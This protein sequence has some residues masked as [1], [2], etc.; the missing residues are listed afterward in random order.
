MSLPGVG[1]RV[2]LI[3]N[4]DSFAHNL[5]QALWGLGAEVTV[6]R[7]DAIDRSGAVA[8]DPTHVVLSPG[9]GR[10]EV[11]RDFGVCAD[12]IDHLTDTPLLGVCLGH[13]GIAWRMGGAVV[14]APEIVHGKVDRITHDGEGLFAGLPQPLPVM[15]Y[16]SLTVDADRLPDCLT[17]TARTAGGLVMGLRHR[18]RPLFGVQFHPESIGTPD[19]PSL[20]ANFLAVRP[21]SSA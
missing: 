2:L 14:R 6:V 10:P 9:P 5:M 15:R 17:V 4:Y 7:N 18:A 1:A 16:H 11:P 12:L 19:G 20:L 3:D 21:G 13:Q 8:A